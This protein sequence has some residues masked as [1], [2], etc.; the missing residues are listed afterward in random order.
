MR[1]QLPSAI[2]GTY[3][4]AVRQNASGDIAVLLSDGSVTET[5]VAKY[6]PDGTESFWTRLGFYESPFAAS[7]QLASDGSVV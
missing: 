4:R 7:M 3:V 6:A 5:I 2:A 1:P